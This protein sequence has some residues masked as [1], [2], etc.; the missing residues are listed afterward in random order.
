MSNEPRRSVPDATLRRLALHLFAL[1]PR[2][3]F[4]FLKAIMNGAPVVDTLEAYERLDP[5]IVKYLGASEML[6]NEEVQ[7]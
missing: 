3:V 1:G 7:P 5:A 4:E 2:C 6:H